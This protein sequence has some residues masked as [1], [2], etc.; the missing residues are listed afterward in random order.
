MFDGHRQFRDDPPL[1]TRMEIDAEAFELINL[2][3]REYRATLQDDRRELLKRYEL[4]DMAHKV[5]GVGSVGLLAFVLL[6]RGRDEDDLMVI[7]VKEA[8]ASVLEAFTATSAFSKHGHRVVTGQR[9]MQAAS[10]SFLGWIDGP[11]GRAF[12]VRQLRDMKWSPDPA[13]LTA[14]KMQPFATLCGHTLARAH[15]RS[16]DAIAIAAYLGSGRKFDKAIAEFSVAYADQV[17][18]D[19]AL[20]VEAIAAGRLTADES[21]DGAEA[22]A[23][24]QG[25]AQPMVKAAAR[26]RAS[27]KRPAKKA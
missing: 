22:K 18:K 27:R 5:V 13:D 7:Q 25:L 1:L 24:L 4:V 8:Q 3:F 2:I 21:A 6:M 15:A 19:F 14:D 12:Y 16:G 20:F 17:E 9:L 26:K 11:N 23:A 10:D